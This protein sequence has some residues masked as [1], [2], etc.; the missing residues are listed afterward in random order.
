MGGVLESGSIVAEFD[1]NGY[2][3]QA[4]DVLTVTAQG[5]SKILTISSMQVNDVNL[6]NDT[7]SGTA[8]PGTEIDV[9]VDTPNP[10]IHRFVQA[11]SS[12]NWVAEFGVAGTP[13]DDPDTVDIQPGSLSRRQCT[14]TTEIGL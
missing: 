1:L 9:C 5:V 4:G 13:P 3:I 6:Q 11:D 12:G 8:A 10:C 14:M 2:D 7:A